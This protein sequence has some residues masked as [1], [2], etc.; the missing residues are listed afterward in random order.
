[1]LHI[2]RTPFPKSNNSKELF[3]TKT[4]LCSKWNSYNIFCFL[5]FAECFSFG[6]EVSNRL[7]RPNFPFVVSIWAYFFPSLS[8]IVYKKNRRVIHRLITSDNKWRVTTNGNE[9]QWVVQV[10]MSDNE[11]QHGVISANF[12][13]FPLREEATTNQSKE[14]SLNLEK[15]HEADWTRRFKEVI[16]V[17]SP[18]TGKYGLEITS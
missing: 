14:N 8:M 15:D 4:T 7:V 11:W 12:P 5:L 3:I 1:M 9:W 18:S 6:E 17:F 16:S 13:F 10:T 2:F